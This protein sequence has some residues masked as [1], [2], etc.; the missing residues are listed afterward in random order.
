ME[1]KNDDEKVN[2]TA[3]TNKWAKNEW[4]RTSAEKKIWLKNNA[5][6]NNDDEKIDIEMDLNEP[7]SNHDND[8]DDDD[9]GIIELNVRGW[10]HL[11]IH[12]LN[13]D[14]QQL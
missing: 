8:D 12:S 2:H 10:R 1:K 9:L 5:K 7:K 6:M 3:T 11:A 13:D 14:G 4:S